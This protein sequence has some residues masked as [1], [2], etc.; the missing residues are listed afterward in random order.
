MTTSNNNHDNLQRKLEHVIS[1]GKMVCAQYPHITCTERSALLLALAAALS[2]VAANMGVV[3]Q[4]QMRYII[5]IYDV[6]FD[7]YGITFVDLQNKIRNAL[8]GA[9]MIHNIDTLHK[10]IVGTDDIMAVEDK[11]YAMHDVGTQQRIGVAR[12]NLI[13][14]ASNLF[15]SIDNSLNSIVSNLKGI[16]KDYQDLEEDP[17]RLHEIYNELYDL[18]KV[19]YRDSIIKDTDVHLE[20]YYSRY[21]KCKEAV[22][23]YIENLTEKLDP[24]TD[25]YI[26]G[27]DPA[28][29]VL[30]RHKFINMQELTFHFETITR[31]DHLIQVLDKV[32]EVPQGEEDCIAILHRLLEGRSGREAAIYVQAAVSSGRM[33]RMNHTKFCEVFGED[34]IKKSMYNDCVGKGKHGLTDNEVEPVMDRYFPYKKK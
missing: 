27:N 1:F 6:D 2:Q 19:Q 20:E 25:E 7:D 21:G 26:K 29:I 16:S 8:A 24:E 18:Y 13:D 3:R 11:L 10:P 28:L 5:N 33:V 9:P 15:W 4:S 34:V 31:Y 32:G 12:K 22:Q 17:K 23:R 14:D 30:L